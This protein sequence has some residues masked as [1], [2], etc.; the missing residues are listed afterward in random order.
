MKLIESNG[1]VI[2]EI[3]GNLFVVD[4]GS[5]LSFNYIGLNQLNID[6]W[7]YAIN[8]PSFCPKEKADDITGVDL[9]GFI[10][11]DILKETNLTIDYVN[12]ELLFGIKEN[13]IPGPDFYFMPFEYL[14]GSYVVT[15]KIL[16]NDEPIGKALI[17][18][19]APTSFVSESIARRLEKTDEHY[20]QDSGMFGVLTG[21]YRKGFM[22][23]NSMAAAKYNM[24]VKVGVVSG[25]L[26]AVAPVDAVIGAN[27][28]SEKCVIFD[29]ENKR[30]GAALDE[31]SKEINRGNY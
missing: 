31:R 5:P 18:T 2:A 23:F 7:D 21:E 28:L 24:S 8:A 29:F 26:G 14:M 20:E 4:T 27:L 19:G 15:D 13:V 1:Y 12:D 30:I 17:D 10:G 11:M 3:E 9:A 22:R 16:L 6:G 25:L